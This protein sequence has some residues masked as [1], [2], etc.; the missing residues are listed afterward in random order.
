MN[1]NLNRRLD[2]A[3]RELKTMLN[4]QSTPRTSPSDPPASMGE[5][6]RAILEL[7]TRVQGLQRIASALYERL[8]PV[9]VPWPSDEQKKGEPAS[10]AS[11]AAVA[12]YDN[13]QILDDV[14]LR[15]NRLHDAISL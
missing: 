6:R 4:A 13:A 9:L 10:F 15:L 3:E 14:F 2:S 7:N 8:E 5:L 12:V 1:L 11:S